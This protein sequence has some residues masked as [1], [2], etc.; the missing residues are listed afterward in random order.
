MNL[1]AVLVRTEYSANIG[2]AARALANMGGQ[3]LILIDPRCEVDESAHQM[4]AGAQ[5]MLNSRVQYK[6]WNDFFA[7]EGD[8]LRI[9]LT[10]RGG[11]K[12]KVFDLDEKLLELKDH[13]ASKGNV[14]LIFGPEAAG[15][16]HDDLAYVN[17]ACHLP[18]YGEFSSLNLAQAVLLAGYIARAHL[19][20]ERLPV[21]DS[22]KLIAV[23]PLF[24]PDELIKQWLEAMGFDVDARRASAYITLR[25]L[26]LHQ[27]P[28][29]HELHVLESILRQ[30]IRKL[31]GEEKV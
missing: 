18:E 6:D 13:D 1:F 11:R 31:R 14:Y 2:S 9:G 26:F 25:R 7:R 24:F 21:E 16:D 27:L 28:T 3:R 4:A 23:Q 12:R 8:G 20:P 15:L 19:K 22:A 5:E 30:N 10:R 29:Q 17:F